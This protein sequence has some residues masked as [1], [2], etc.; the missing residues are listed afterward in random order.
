MKIHSILQVAGIA[1]VALGIS[2]WSIP[3]GVIALGLGAVL[4]G[5]A[6]ERK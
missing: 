1:V 6:L 3:A 2:I 4:I 5:I